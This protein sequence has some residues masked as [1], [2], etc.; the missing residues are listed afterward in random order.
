VTHARGALFLCGYGFGLFALCPVFI[1]V[2]VSVFVCRIRPVEMR[3]SQQTAPYK[4]TKLTFWNEVT[5][6]NV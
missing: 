6:E 5:F 1:F 4:Q 3:N 2:F